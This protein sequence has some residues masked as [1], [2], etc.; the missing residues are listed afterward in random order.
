MSLVSVEQVHK[1]YGEN[2]VLKGVDLK[3]NP[4]EVVSI[5]GRSGSGKSTLLRCMN[6]LEDY[7]EGVIIVDSQ[8]VENDDYKLRLLS[9]S[10]GMV[11]Q[12]FNLFPHM[13]VGENVMLAPKLVLKKSSEACETLARELLEKVG[14]A[15]KFDAYPTNLSGGQQQRVAIARSLAMNPKV[16]LCDEITSALDPELVGEVLK[17]LEQLKAEGMTLILVTHEV[18]FARDVGDRVVF[19]NQG[20]VWETGPSEAVFAAPQTPE[21][22]SFLSAVR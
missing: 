6:G 8:A 5:I 4:G 13:T 22:Q 11:F 20:K 12:S 21:L 19:M 1:Y 16:L 7:Q 15:D 3:I 17:V 10:V 9:R 18:N 2:H 14:L